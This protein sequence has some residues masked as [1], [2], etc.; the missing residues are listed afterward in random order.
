MMIPRFQ[1]FREASDAFSVVDSVSGHKVAEGVSFEAAKAIAKEVGKLFEKRY[2]LLDAD[3]NIVVESD[4]A[5]ML[6]PLLGKRG[7]TIIDR[8]QPERRWIADPVP[9]IREAAR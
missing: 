7:V 9:E 2:A 3:E 6:L 8:L 1:L 5:G 4:E